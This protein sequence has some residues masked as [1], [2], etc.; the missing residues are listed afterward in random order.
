MCSTTDAVF[1]DATAAILAAAVPT[2]TVMP[3]GFTSSTVRL[4]SESETLQA[5]LYGELPARRAVVLVHGQDWDGA[6]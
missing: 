5:D 3:N 1:N 2:I 4:A 6:G